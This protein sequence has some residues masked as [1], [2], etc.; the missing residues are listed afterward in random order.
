MLRYALAGSPYYAGDVGG[1]LGDVDEQLLVRWYQAAAFFP[2]MRVHNA[3]DGASRFPTDFPE[4]TLA[5]L[6][7]AVQ[8]RYQM[9]PLLRS[10]AYELAFVP[11][12]SRSA[13]AGRTVQRHLYAEAP[14]SGLPPMRPMLM[15]YPGDA[16]FAKESSQWMVGD[17]LLVAPQITSSNTRQVALPVGTWFSFN[18]TQT[19]H[20]PADVT[21]SPS[22]DEI[23]VLVRAGSVFAVGDSVMATADAPQRP[24]LLHI[25]PGAN[26]TFVMREDDG[27]TYGG[28]ARVTTFIWDDADLALLWSAEG[29]YSG[30]TTYTLVQAVAFFPDADPVYT[31]VRDIG[32]GGFFTFAA[33]AAADSSDRR[34]ATRGNLQKS[35]SSGG[36][37]LVPYR[38]SR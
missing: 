6:R 9:L 21:V 22:L 19:A 27:V 35:S 26:A 29:S 33:A 34:A 2:I 31:R 12:A 36:D 4:P 30:N 5:R 25:Y 13:S 3:H 24:L 14:P 18:T 10:L 38:L 16:R 7:A 23:F 20:G 32:D 37:E 17:R 1:S 11:S 8:L 28:D 15:V